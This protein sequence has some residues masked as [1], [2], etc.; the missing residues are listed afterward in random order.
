MF[1]EHNIVE[2]LKCCGFR[3]VSK[4]RFEEGLDQEE[5]RY[6]SIYFVAKK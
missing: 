5:R 3:E 6:D 2:I 1:D 4:R